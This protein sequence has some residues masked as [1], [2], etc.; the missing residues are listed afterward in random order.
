MYPSATR[1]TGVAVTNLPSGERDHVPTKVQP[2]APSEPDRP[3][4]FPFPSTESTSGSEE[5]ATLP[6][7]AGSTDLGTRYDDPRR[8]A[9]GLLD[10]GSRAVAGRQ[11]TAGEGERSSRFA[12]KRSERT[13]DRGG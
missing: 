2:A 1:L 10:R 3:A 13:T 12:I 9:I 5:N 8:S 6:A 7:G 11:P 4:C